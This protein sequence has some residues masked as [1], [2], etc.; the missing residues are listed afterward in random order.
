[1]KR[2]FFWRN[3]IRLMVPV[4][5]PII[6]LSPFSMFITFNYA[7][8][9]SNQSSLETLKLA[10]ENLELMLN[11]ADFLTMS[12]DDNINNASSV[13]SVLR[14][15]VFTYEIAKKME[16]IKGLIAIPT[17]SKPFIHSIYIYVDNQYGRFLPSN[18][19][20]ASISSTFDGSWY[21]TYINTKPD[22]RQWAETRQIMSYTGD[23]NPQKVITLYRRLVNNRGVIVLNI[24]QSYFYNMIRQL[25]GFNGRNL[26]VISP[27]G[28]LLFSSI[29][30]FNLADSGLSFDKYPVGEPVT[31]RI[32]G[33]NQLMTMLKSDKFNWTYVSF[34]PSSMLYSIPKRILA[35]TLA[36]LFITVAIGFILS[37]FLT[38]KNY[39]QIMNIINVFQAAEEGKPLPPMSEHIGDEYSYIL[40]NVLKTFIEHDYLKIQLSLKQLSLKNAELLA[41][42]SQLNPH[43]IFNTLETIN[44]EILS[45]TK[46]PTNANRMIEQLGHMLRYVLDRPGETVTL[47]EEIDNTK[48][49]I[50]IQTYRYEDKFF[51]RWNVDDAAL[52]FPIIP[53]LLQPLIENSI[54]HGIKEKEGRCGIK[55]SMHIEPSGLHIRI[56]DNGLGIVPED[57]SAIRQKLIH[58]EIDP[59]RHIGLYNA[60]KR[61][62]L[63]FG[64][65]YSISIRSRYTVGTYIHIFLPDFGM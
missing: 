13:K 61:L 18:A 31:V 9:Q 27:E 39:R 50:E 35:L 19:S 65:K 6:L 63:T 7:V 44:L 60:N 17:Y 47:K 58:P 26:V 1:M 57:L 54:Y 25:T 21:E 37:F 22:V 29:H 8:S 59:G 20:I 46:R 10:K 30:G 52:D 45:L 11:D 53:L 12:L 51:V 23:E 56:T 14:T 33:E 36:I 42:Q 55:L 64:E 40:Q 24:R 41:L 48:R 15:P 28:E 43:F 32:N 38:R 49:Y 5:L 16:F 3:F 62:A 34:I 2:K 4:L